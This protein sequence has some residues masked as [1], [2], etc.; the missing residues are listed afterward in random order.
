MKN[1]LLTLATIAAIGVM[2]TTSTG[3]SSN[4]DPREDEAYLRSTQ[5]LGSDPINVFNGA[6]LY[7]VVANGSYVSQTIG[8][9][10]QFT[11]QAYLTISGPGGNLGCS[12]PGT[13][14]GGG[15]S[16][17]SSTST[18]T[19]ATSTATSYAGGSS[20]STPKI[21]SPGGGSSYRI[22]YNSY[23]GWYVWI[24]A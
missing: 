24:Y 7:R 5:S 9:P 18:T 15:G 21:Y 10:Q 3:C 19:F 11:S 4:D 14:P 1:S 16:S 20:T 2:A 8:A 12:V 22:A 17:S 6:F 23:Y 13:P